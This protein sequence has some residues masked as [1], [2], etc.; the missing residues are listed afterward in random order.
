MKIALIAATLLIPLS[1]A[2][3]LTGSVVDTTGASIPHASVELDSPSTKYQARADDAGAFQF[4]N[5]PAGEYG[6]KITVPGFKVLNLTAIKISES[7]HKHLPYVPLDV[8]T[9]SP[10]SRQLIML[11]T[12]ILFGHLSGSVTPKVAGVEV[13]LIC[14]TF[15]ACRSTKTDSHGRFSFEMLSAGVYGLSFRRAGFYPEIATGYEYYVN[16]AWDSVYTPVSLEKCRNGNCDPK[17]RPK[18]PV[19]ICE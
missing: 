11:Q 8:G 10:I 12:A 2:S 1:E 14:R 3:S 19:R 17:R 15:Q 16:T 18:R 9:C 7:E 5:L 13:T 4:L 6:L